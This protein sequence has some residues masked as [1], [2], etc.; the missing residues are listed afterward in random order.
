MLGYYKSTAHIADVCSTSNARRSASTYSTE[1]YGLDE[2]CATADDAT[3]EFHSKP[4]TGER[5]STAN[6]IAAADDYAA[7]GSFASGKY[8]HSTA[9][10]TQQY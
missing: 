1:Y 9:S 5:I 6:D 3:T 8:G 7:N 10:A 2:Q 4:G